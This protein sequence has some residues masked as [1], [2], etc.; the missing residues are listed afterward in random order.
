LKNP[1][2]FHEKTKDFILRRT[3]V[4][5]LRDLPSMQRKFFHCE[6]DRKVNKAYA[7][8]L[9]E[10]EDLYYN[11][12][13]T[14]AFQRNSNMLAIM[15]KMRQVTAVGKVDQC[16]DFVT[17]FLESSDRKIAIFAH[18]EMAISLL[19]NKINSYLIENKMHEVLHLH[20]GLNAFK[21]TELIEHF[22]NSDARVMIAST[23]A[24]GEGLNIQFVS[25]A[26]MFERQWNPANEEQAEGRFHR[27]GQ[28]NA[29]SITYMIASETI[30]E[31]FTE[32]V[33]SK[34]AIVASTMDNKEVQWDST[35]LMTELANILVTK[36]KKAWSLK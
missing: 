34:R 30:D 7:A 19:L 5:V 31:Y 15:T 8:A 35:S 6:L 28:K 3:K 4:E 9:Q 36:G 26:I 2:A 24:A 12:D 29:V 23:L 1:A 27:F 33:E 32:L 20:S 22:K 17:E 21:R 25:D 11:E 14:D 10:L 13:E 18:H 16:V